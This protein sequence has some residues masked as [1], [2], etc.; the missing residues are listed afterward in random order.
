MLKGVLVFLILADF[1]ANYAS[2]ADN[3]KPVSSAA[4]ILGLKS[5]RNR[6]KLYQPV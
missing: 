1:V 2:L 5:G 6:R 4:S 3:E